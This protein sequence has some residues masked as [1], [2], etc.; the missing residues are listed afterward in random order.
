MHASALDISL[1]LLHFDVKVGGH[2]LG[3]L[4]L[5]TPAI[6]RS[7]FDLYPGEIDSDLAAELDVDADRIVLLKAWESQQ[8]ALRG[9]GQ[10][11]RP[12][13]RW[14]F[15][16]L[17]RRYADRW[18]YELSEKATLISWPA[19]ASQGVPPMLVGESY[20]YNLVRAACVWLGAVNETATSTSL[21][22]MV[23]APS[24][25]AAHNARFAL[26]HSPNAGI[27]ALIEKYERTPPRPVSESSEIALHVQVE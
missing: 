3:E 15:P 7:C 16:L 25:V 24:L 1:D 13:A 6:P 18:Q 9:P 21:I 12:Q 5:L 8:T 22:E 23:G 19:P 14:L 17:G 11:L 10:P 4:A 26:R 27:R 2:P 20:D